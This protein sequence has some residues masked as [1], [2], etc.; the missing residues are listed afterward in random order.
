[1][2]YHNCAEQVTLLE[3]RGEVEFEDAVTALVPCDS[4]YI[5][6]GKMHC[7]RNTGDAPMRNLWILRQQ[8]R[9][10]NI[11]YNPR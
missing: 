4:T 3:G 2:H 5:P 1:M 7:F 8:R 11:S 10:A 9:H 6:A